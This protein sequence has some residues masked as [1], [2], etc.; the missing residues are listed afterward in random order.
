MIHGLQ[1]PLWSL[2][3]F[4]NALGSRGGIVC[5]TA[6]LETDDSILDQKAGQALR[7]YGHHL[8]VGNLLQ[9]HRTR[10]WLYARD[11]AGYK[12]TMIEAR[13]DT[14]NTLLEDDLID[15]VVHKHSQFV[16]DSNNI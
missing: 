12:P 7:R 11:S 5:D 3:R 1:V 9:S 8:V 2:S 16:G 6:Q 15:I 13:S 4:V 14:G 10:V